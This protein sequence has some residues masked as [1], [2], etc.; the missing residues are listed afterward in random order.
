MSADNGKKVKITTADGKVYVLRYTRYSC[1]QIGKAGFNLN[2]LFTRPTTMVPLLV[3]GA[4]IPDNRMMSKETAMKIW[5]TIKGKNPEKDDEDSLTGVLVE[6][7]SDCI[8]TL[9]DD[10]DEDEGNASTWE[11]I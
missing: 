5:N 4:F 6:M 2:E 9:F 8:N 7:Y 1:D 10:P 3:W 11:V